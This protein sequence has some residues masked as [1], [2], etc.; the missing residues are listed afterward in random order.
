M[1]LTGDVIVPK[2]P[3]FGA[4]ILLNNPFGLQHCQESPRNM[5]FVFNMS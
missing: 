2:G 5:P 1:S 3:L 4:F